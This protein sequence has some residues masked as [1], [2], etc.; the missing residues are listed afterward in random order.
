MKKS[1]LLTCAAMTL[2]LNAHAA[3]EFDELLRVKKFTEAEQAAS[4]KL[5]KEPAHADALIAKSEAILGLGNEER[6]DESIK[7]AEQCVAASLNNANC[8]VALGSARGAKAMNGGMLAA[9]GLAG[10]I[11]DNFQKAVQ[12]DPKNVDA[13]FSLMQFYLMAPGFMGGGL[14]KAEA[15]VAQTTASHPEAGKLL[16]VSIDLK[17]DRVAKAEA[18][19]LAARPGADADLKKLHESAI[20]SVG[21]KYLNTKKYADAERMFREAQ[22]Q[23]PET[24]SGAYFIARNYQEQGK[25]REAIATFDALIA[26]Y[27]RP[28][29]HYRVAQS[30]QALGDKIKAVA[31]Y[32]KALGYK[33]GLYKQFRA[34]SEKQLK[35]LKG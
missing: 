5:A 24:G 33:S 23:Y 2:A 11:R 13:R 27:P 32:E 1:L 10:K 14:D 18:T 30:Q 26:S 21:N 31:A 34:D 6:I 3:N 22:K 17:A 15:L 9:A 19:A 25:H 7:L 8:Y 28:H 20:M 35:A 4:A 16:M 12:L 29:L